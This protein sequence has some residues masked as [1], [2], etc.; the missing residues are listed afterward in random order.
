V[1]PDPS[2]AVEANLVA[3]VKFLSEDIGVRS[4]RDLTKLNKT[5]DY[6]EEQ[7]RTFGCPVTRQAFSYDGRTYY[8]IAAEVKGR[9]PEQKG[10]VIVGAHYDSAGHTPGAD[11]NASGVAGL[12]EL[13]RLFMLEPADRTVRFVAFSLDNLVR[14][15]SSFHA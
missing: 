9:A 4:Y 12:L 5:A 1:Q 3:S 8:N 6:I 11:D 14:S 7:F 2:T 15:P 10:I 13:A